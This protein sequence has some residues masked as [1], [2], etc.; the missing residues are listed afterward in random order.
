MVNLKLKRMKG[1]ILELT[2]QIAKLDADRSFYKK[3]SEWLRL[4]YVLVY[5]LEILR[6]YEKETGC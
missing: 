6:E 2:D 1:R 4:M 3:Q 5:E